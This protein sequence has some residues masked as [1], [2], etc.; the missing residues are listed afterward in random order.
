MPP[1][2]PNQPAAGGLYPV[3][4]GPQRECRMPGDALRDLITRLRHGGDAAGL[5]DAQLLARFAA[6]RD[7]AAFELLVW[8]HGGLVL[9]AA[10]RLLGDEVDAEDAFQATFLTLAR[11]AGS[12][13]RGE[14]LAAWLHQVVC[15]IARRERN[16]RALRRVVEQR[17]IGTEPGR[18][19]PQVDDLGPLLDD[20]VARLPERYRRVV[21]LCYL[22][23]C[24]VADA[25][26]ALG[27][28]RGTVLSRLAAAREML[29]RR[30]VRR[31]IA[32][33]VAIGISGEVLSAPPS[34]KLVAAAV[35]LAGPAVE[36]PASIIQMS[37]GVIQ[38]MFWKKCRTFIALALFAGICGVGIGAGRG[39]QPAPGGSRAAKPKDER[40]IGVHKEEEVPP[41][42]EADVRERLNVELQQADKAL[43]DAEAKFAVLRSDFRA[44]V[45]ASEEKLRELEHRQAW[46]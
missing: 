27:C 22:Q 6:Y 13:R 38:A 17:L 7:E 25:A 26:A 8:R 24:G 29:K 1:N 44:R 40:L 11:K 32:P 31:G 28:P 41:N 16:R 18:D 45:I 37:N 33:A 39:D 2:S 34:A 5:S 43:E 19:D 9:G 42:D 15:R 23:G 4:M 10:K 12:V 21:L 35:R 14:A 30:L 3:R 20:E 36:V 46:E